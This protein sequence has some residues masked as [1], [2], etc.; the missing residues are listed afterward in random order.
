MKNI[1]IFL[2][3]LL[4]LSSC[5][6]DSKLRIKQFETELGMQKTEALTSSVELLE[7]TLMEKY[8]GVSLEEA[9]SKYL[10][11]L[12]T[13]ELAL[14]KDVAQAK[15]DALKAR[16]ETSNFKKDIWQEVDSVK[17]QENSIMCYYTYN[18]ITKSYLSTFKALPQ[19]VEVDS[20]VRYFKDYLTKGE[21]D[22]F[23]KHVDT[24][25]IK[26][27]RVEL[28]ELEDSLVFITELPIPSQ[29]LSYDTK[30]ITVYLNK[31]P[32]FNMEGDFMKGLDLIQASDSMV[33][34]Y[35]SSKEA[36]TNIPILA[37]VDGLL[38][39]NVDYT[40]YFVKRIIVVE[41]FLRMLDIK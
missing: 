26:E 23:F 7:S 35:L 32:S 12:M 14:S 17:I 13:E 2:S 40:D 34:E 8:K 20:F 1:L 30:A 5:Q 39:G 4:Y 22:D 19:F 38:K 41:L 37:I 24:F 11:E 10:R 15:I 21:V 27:D 25:M 28:Y 31:N 16:L 3:L 18:N 6:D 29:Y 36:T 33:I 9:Y